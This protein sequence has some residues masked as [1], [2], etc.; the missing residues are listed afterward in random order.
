MFVKHG[1]QTDPAASQEVPQHRPIFVDP[2]FDLIVNTE[3]SSQRLQ[4]K[5]SCFV[6][7]VPNASGH[8][9]SNSRAVFRVKG[10]QAGEG[11]EL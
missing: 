3:A 11:F 7:F 8:D 10:E 9:E 2:E 1:M 5:H 4:L 6:S